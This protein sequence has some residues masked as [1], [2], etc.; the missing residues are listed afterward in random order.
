MITPNLK[1]F[2]QTFLLV[3][4]TTF[5]IL[6]LIIQQAKYE[7]EIWAKHD[8]CTSYSNFGEDE[9]YDPYRNDQREMEMYF[10]CMQGGDQ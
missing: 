2:V 3:F 5:V 6:G 8:A 10:D 1:T 9:P 4:C 7:K